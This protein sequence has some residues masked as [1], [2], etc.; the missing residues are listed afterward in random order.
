MKK[1][2]AVLLVVLSL[3]SVACADCEWWGEYHTDEMLYIAC[4]YDEEAGECFTAVV[5]IF[6]LEAMAWDDVLFSA[7][8]IDCDG[9]AE[10]CWT[11]ETDADGN[12]SSFTTWAVQ[13]ENGEWKLMEALEWVS[14]S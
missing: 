2:V 11:Y 4:G 14:L 8:V 5:D 13:W 12:Y 1:M 3:V 10:I 7:Y 9:I 6:T